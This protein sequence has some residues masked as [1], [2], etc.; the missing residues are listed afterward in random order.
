MIPGPDRNPG[1]PALNPVTSVPLTPPVLA[2]PSTLGAPGPVVQVLVNGAV[3]SALLETSWQRVLSDPGEGSATVPNGAASADYGD[4]L[5]FSMGGKVRHQALIERINEQRI[6][7]NE[8]AGENTTY[9]GRGLSAEW[10]R[11]VIYPDLGAEHPERL[12]PPKQDSRFFNWTASTGID[13]T[14]WGQAVITPARYGKTL[15]DSGGGQRFYYPEGWPWNQARWIWDRETSNGAPVGDVYFRKTFGAGAGIYQIWSCADDE[16]ELWINGIKIAERL[17]VYSGQA[18]HVEIELGEHFH[19]LAAKAKNRKGR[20]GLQV[21]VLP[22]KDFGQLGVAI[23]QTDQSWKVKG[24]PKDPP[25]MT[26]GQA[27]KIVHDEAKVRGMLNNWTLGFGKDNDSAGKP[28]PILSDLSVPVGTTGLGF[29]SQLSE[30]HIDWSFSPA[31]RKLLC[32]NIDTMGHSSAGLT[33]M[34]ELN[35][36]G[37]G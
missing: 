36:S 21:A 16:Y 32:Y 13:D 28:W 37:E 5:T 34:T 10:D 35:V 2:P 31:Q 14:Q 17:G 30:A 15:L 4:I 7:A 8:E 11:M 33:P 23:E 1:P 6:D 19:L 24:Y 22:V 26:V 27:I 12:A 29:L 3:P 9:S 18:E 20:A 25:G